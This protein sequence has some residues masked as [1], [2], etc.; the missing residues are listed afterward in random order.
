MA[1]KRCHTTFQGAP[2]IYQPHTRA[3]SSSKIR[4]ILV[5]A[6]EARAHSRPTAC[7]MPKIHMT[8]G[9]STRTLRLLELVDLLTAV[10]PR[11]VGIG[12][13][14]FSVPE[15]AVFEEHSFYYSSELPN[16]WYFTAAAAD[17]FCTT[18]T[19][20]EQSRIHL[21]GHHWTSPSPR[22]RIARSPSI[23]LRRRDSRK[24][25]TEEHRRRIAF[26]PGSCPTPS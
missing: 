19:R 10:R 4:R 6:R 23:E 17:A 21:P 26:A 7:T 1:Q 9:L 2:V 5:P 12:R 11:K 18:L 16:L 13:V 3:R 8:C 22:T 14:S 15:V 24:S 25:K 20:I